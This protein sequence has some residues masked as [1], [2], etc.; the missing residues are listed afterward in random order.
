MDTFQAESDLGEPQV[1]PSAVTVH[2]PHSMGAMKT[3]DSG[4]RQL[5]GGWCA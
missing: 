2:C 1:S 5:G 4:G 3:D